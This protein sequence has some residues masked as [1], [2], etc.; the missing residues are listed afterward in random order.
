MFGK[1]KRPALRAALGKGS[2]PG[3]RAGLGRRG[4]S[5]AQARRDREWRRFVRDLTEPAR[6]ISPA[7]DERMLRFLESHS[8]DEG[9]REPPAER[10]A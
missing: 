9:S 5:R 10:A 4:V 7:E 2:R 1:G 8:R 6:Q 3:L